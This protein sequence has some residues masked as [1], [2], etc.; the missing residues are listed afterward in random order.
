MIWR[1]LVLA[2]ALAVTPL[3]SAHALVIGAQDGLTASPDDLSATRGLGATV[4][5]I[6]IDPSKPLAMYDPAIQ[7]R[8]DAGMRPQLVIGGLFGGP[9]PTPAQAVAVLRR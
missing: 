8:R 5:R 9:M 4:A 6:L 3:P 7:A 1:A 2:I